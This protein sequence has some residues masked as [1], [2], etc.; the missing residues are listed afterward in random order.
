[1]KDITRIGPCI[2]GSHEELIN[3]KKISPANINIKVRFY[4]NKK[5]GLE[6]HEYLTLF[7]NKQLPNCY[8]VPSGLWHTKEVRQPK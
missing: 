3:G 1:M 4:M 8:N 2:G 7:V 6:V 5:D